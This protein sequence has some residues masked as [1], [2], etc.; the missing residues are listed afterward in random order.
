[1]ANVSL[2]PQPPLIDSVSGCSP[3]RS[4]SPASS[5]SSGSSP[6]APTVCLSDISP[7]PY[8]VLSLRGSSENEV[9]EKDSQDVLENVVSSEP[10]RGLGLH[11]LAFSRQAGLYFDAT[12]VPFAPVSSPTSFPEPLSTSSSASIPQKRRQ[13]RSTTTS[14]R[15]SRVEFRPDPPTG[16]EI[17]NQPSRTVQS[18][19]PSTSRQDG[20]PVIDYSAGRRRKFPL[21]SAVSPVEPLQPSPSLQTRRIIS[22]RSSSS[23][24]QSI[25]QPTPSDA[26]D[27][28]VTDDDATG[29]YESDDCDGD[30]DPD[31]DDYGRPRLSKRP[32][33]A[34][35]PAKAKSKP[36][37][38]KT[39][40]PRHTKGKRGFHCPEPGCDRTFTRNSDAQRHFTSIHQAVKQYCP[41]CLKKLSRKD[42]VTRHATNSEVCNERAAKRT[43]SYRYLSV[44]QTK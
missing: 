37:P 14:R 21:Q 13:A 2:R 1:M 3:F 39:T 34:A 28:M 30:D 27:D 15:P 44:L 22:L 4:I 25:L 43:V 9:S 33:K 19:A 11:N 12:S 36:S 31:D 29:N 20:I 35:K 5:I 16:W 38:R 8:Y 7:Q 40:K 42:A 6:D 26:S 17:P 32:R 24:V 10:T 18:L 23:R 41:H